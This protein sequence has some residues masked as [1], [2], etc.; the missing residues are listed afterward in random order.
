VTVLS[1]YSF[2]WTSA[3]LLSRNKWLKLIIWHQQNK[4]FYLPNISSSCSQNL[5]YRIKTT[6]VRQSFKA[7]CQSNI[8]YLQQHLYKILTTTERFITTANLHI[9][10]VI[11]RIL[12][13]WPNRGP[14]CKLYIVHNFRYWT[15]ETHRQRPRMRICTPDKEGGLWQRVDWHTIQKGRPKNW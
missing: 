9:F 2:N 13:T 7:D 10:S 8:R 11:T 6:F 4:S 12:D 5:A 1:T 14:A 15:T 3:G